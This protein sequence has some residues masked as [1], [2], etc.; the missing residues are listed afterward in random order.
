MNFTHVKLEVDGA[1]ATLAFN[2]PDQLNAMNAAMMREIISAL[3]YIHA[4]PEIRIGVLTGEGKAFMAGADIKEY[5]AQSAAQFDDFTWRG[6]HLYTLLESSNKPMIA[7]VNGYAFGGGFEIALSCDLILARKG[8]KFGLPEILLNL[9]PGGGGTQRLVQKIGLNRANELLMTGRTVT[10]EEL[11]SWGCVNHLYD[12]ETFHEQTM[13][14]ARELAKKEPEPLRVIK[15]LT[16]L[17]AAP[18]SGPALTL[19]SQAVSRYF[20]SP[21]GQ[22]KIQEFLNKSLSKKAN[23]PA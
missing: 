20:H 3:E 13:S 17:A 16:R 9:I 10:A 12:A 23:P 11:A 19:E 1:V 2:R 8:A 6:R 18:V 15:Q 14:F 22:L 7:A 4:D 5:A 21:A